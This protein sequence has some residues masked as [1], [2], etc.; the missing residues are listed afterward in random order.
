M[1]YENYDQSKALYDVLTQVF[2]DYKHGAV[3]GGH[4]W[5]MPATQVGGLTMRY[6]GDS[7]LELTYHRYEV[8]SVEQLQ[9][10]RQQDDG[11][12]FLEATVKA[13][14]KE[15]KEATGKQ[16]TLKK[17]KEETPYFEKAGRVTAESSW[18]LGSSRHGHGARPVGRYLVRSTCLYDFN[19]KL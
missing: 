7:L 16:I 13:L 11:P 15:F 2:E 8:A 14:K 1:A 6:K 3:S 17:V 19:A 18:L 5:N 4:T 10:I 9:R 12:K